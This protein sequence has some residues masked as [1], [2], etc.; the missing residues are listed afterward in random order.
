M[1][2]MATDSKANG[3]KFLIVYAGELDGIRFDPPEDP[4]LPSLFDKLDPLPADG[5]LDGLRDALSITY[6]QCKIFDELPTMLNAIRGTLLKALI[7]LGKLLEELKL[8][9]VGDS[10]AVPPDTD[11]IMHKFVFAPT[12][13]LRR[14]IRTDERKLKPVFELMECQAGDKAIIAARKALSLTFCESYSVLQYRKVLGDIRKLAAEALAPCN[15]CL[16]AIEREPVAIPT[17]WGH[18]NL[19]E[20]LADQNK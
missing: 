12:K 10:Y 4:A 9:P 11:Q 20:D 17:I 1:S 2:A 3:A 13:E 8:K 19:E 7:P 6:R 5:V 16:E 18:E 15:W 14:K